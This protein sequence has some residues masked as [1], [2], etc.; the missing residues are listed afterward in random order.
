MKTLLNMRDTVLRMA[1]LVTASLV[2]ANPALAGVREKV[3]E[4]R[5]QDRIEVHFD[6]FLMD[7]EEGRAALRR[8]VR[9]AAKSICTANVAAISGV[10]APICGETRDVAH[11]AG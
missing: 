2:L 11:A 6:A 9:D 5:L 3:V 1:G 10:K 7:T 4:E 8:D